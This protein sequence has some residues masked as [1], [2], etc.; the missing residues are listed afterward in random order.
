MRIFALTKEISEIKTEN[1]VNIPWIF[2]NSKKIMSKWK[3]LLQKCDI[4]E[5]FTFH[6]Q[7]FEKNPVFQG[8]PDSLTHFSTPCV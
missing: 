1:A 2:G 7:G 8:N 3:I 6:C 5:L 4:T